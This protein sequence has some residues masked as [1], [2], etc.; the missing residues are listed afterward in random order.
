[1]SASQ[2]PRGAQKYVPH[3]R[4]GQDRRARHA[5]PGV[6]QD[7]RTR[8][9]VLRALL[10]S[11]AAVTTFPASTA[12]GGDSTADG[13]VAG[14]DSGAGGDRDHD[15]DPDPGSD[16]DA[17]FDETYRGRRIQG[18]PSPLHRAPVTTGAASAA[19]HGQWQVT[20][21]GRPLPLMRR[22]DG[23]YL[24]MVDH[25]RSYPTAREAARAAVDEL[26]PVLSPREMSHT[27]AEGREGDG[28]GGGHGVHA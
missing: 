11:G 10:A 13:D 19:G 27:A 26:G 21:D 14:R 20:V 9:A 6:W 8:R 4:A 18:T 16:S 25:Y 2:H 17:G 28:D 23:S 1:M 22:A 15:S 3:D 24:S 5:R 12:L 7:G